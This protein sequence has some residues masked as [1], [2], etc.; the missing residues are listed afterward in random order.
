MWQ[1]VFDNKVKVSLA[2]DPLHPPWP[3]QTSSGA[4]PLVRATLSQ[5]EYLEQS[6]ISS[7]KAAET[8]PWVWGHSFCLLSLQTHLELIHCQGI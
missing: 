1:E 7:G 4:E 2:R 8:E 6:A 3:F 5:S